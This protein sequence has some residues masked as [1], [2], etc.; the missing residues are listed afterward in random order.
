MEV[1]IYNWEYYKTM[2]RDYAETAR[3]I[4]RVRWQFVHSVHPKR[5]LDYGCGCNFF[6]LFAPNGVEI[7]SYD[8]GK[9]NGH[10]YPQTGIN[11]EYYDL[12]TLWDVLEHIA[13]DNNPDDLLLSA[14]RNT[15]YVA[16]SVPVLPD[17]KELVTWKHYKPK[18]HLT[19]FTKDTLR[20]FFTDKNLELLKLDCVECP[21]R[22]DIVSSLWRRRHE[23]R[24]S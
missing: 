11:H 17:G 19:Y 24:N 21:P 12:V 2:L 22:E 20:D 13:W 9:I 7:D 23:A 5:V 8:I 15:R 6:S 18:E 1:S 16:A 10:P 3:H 4:S 14:L